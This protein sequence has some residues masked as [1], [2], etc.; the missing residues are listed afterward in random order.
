MS[1]ISANQNKITDVIPTEYED[2]LHYCSI[3]GRVYTDEITQVDLIAYRSQY[4][5]TKSE[6]KELQAIINAG[7][8]LNPTSICTERPGEDC[9]LTEDDNDSMPIPVVDELIQCPNVAAETNHDQ[10]S[11]D[12]T[13]GQSIAEPAQDITYAELFGVSPDGCEEISISD[14]F[15]S[16]FEISF[17]VRVMNALSREK[18]C[19]LSDL[20]SLTPA[21]LHE[22]R[23]LGTK[24]FS[25]IEGAISK[26]AEMIKANGTPVVTP[27]ASKDRY[28]FSRIRPELLRP[29][30]F[31]LVNQEPVETNGLFPSEVAYLEEVQTAVTEI[32]KELCM[33]ILNKESSD[34]IRSICQMLQ[35]FHSRTEIENSI[36]TGATQ[37]M[38][39]W[40]TYLFDKKLC[41]F[42]RYYCKTIKDGLQV[43]LPSIFD[44]GSY[45]SQYGDCITSLLKENN[46]ELH[47]IAEQLVKFQT[48]ME[49]IDLDGLVKHV[50][51]SL[52]DKDD[53]AI[54]ILYARAKGC[55]LEEVGQKLGGVT[56]ER[57]R[58]LEKKACRIIQHRFVHGKYNVFAL[59]YALRDGDVVLTQKEIAEVVKAEDAEIIWY[60]ATRSLTK[61]E[62]HLLDTKYA[63]YDPVHDV[64]V[65]TLSDY[66]QAS[67]PK[68]VS[69]PDEII[70]ALPAIIETSKLTEAASDIARRLDIPEEISLL[71][72]F[73]RYHKAGEFSYRGRLTIVQICD[74][75]LKYRFPNGYKI[76]DETDS[77]IFLGYM[78]SMFG[79][80]GR[81]TARAVDAKVMDMGILIDRGK[82]IHKDLIQF[83][84]SLLNTVFEYISSSPKNALTYTEIFASLSDLFIGTTIT[85]RY[86]LQGA[87][88]ACGCPFESHRDYIV[89]NGSGNVADELT[90]F[91]QANGVV[92]KTEI[93]AEFPGWKDYNLSFILPRC[94]DVIGIDNGYF[95]HSD[96]L[97]ISEN[98]RDKIHRY[99]LNNIQDI[100]VS[101][102]F[103]QDEFM[104][105]YPDF[106]IKNDIQSHG[107]LF[108]ILQYMF[109][110]EFHF[111][112]PYIARENIGEITNKSVLLQHIEGVTSIEIADFL[113]LCKQNSI[114]Y[115]SVSN[116][117]DMMQPDLIRVD[118]IT[119]MRQ[120]DLG[121]DEQVFQDV[122]DLIT[123]EV[124]AHGGYIA[125][126]SVEDFSWYPVL[127]VEWNPFLL[128]S[129][130]AMIPTGINTVKIVS[131]SS[132]IPHSIFVS[133][134]Y[135][136]DDWSSLLVKLLKKEHEIEPFA[137]KSDIL[138]WLQNEGLCNVNYPAFLDSE[139]HVVFDDDG[140]MRIQ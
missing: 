106:M 32:G 39:N 83:D 69:V 17:S 123:N 49:T 127:N 63:H 132:E 23:N 136:E 67:T 74:Y 111:S 54:E 72:L 1:I 99:L 101:A 62:T 84:Q 9:N 96:T 100:P 91:V 124:V 98:D 130:A 12:E 18:C 5:R 58:Q 51:N 85:N 38:L 108:G 7:V 89:K 107:K 20:L 77:N 8:I 27:K 129:I 31:S 10:V 53:R 133:E 93:L 13:T 56:R 126:N 44:E 109:G 131:S 82:Y 135:S 66:R 55:T 34:Q 81:T 104:L 97:K 75:I 76:S 4:G 112:R 11:F 60:C 73:S 24:S 105:R 86:V 22:I 102:R 70:D 64:I 36:I 57:I 46:S 42:V 79:K 117:L 37:S 16:L 118:E 50:F 80:S 45:V 78:D 48:W 138:Q 115:V 19:S 59:I 92:H 113:D 15:Y 137:S 3:A 103:L 87:M 26:I 139:H 2:F 25:E 47:T 121:I 125:A 61:G 41:P 65:V 90:S 14:D 110:G 128:E 120:E 21:G 88:K 116:L 114:Q 30:V 94:P 29:L 122:T 28:D 33:A 43:N 140:K 95:I 6:I 40:P 71:S 119:L 68:K 52:G 134:E 35:E